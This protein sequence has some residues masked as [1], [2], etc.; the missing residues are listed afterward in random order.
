MISWPPNMEGADVIAFPAR[1]AVPAIAALMLAV[2]CLPAVAQD[3]PRLNTNQQYVEENSASTTLDTADPETGIES[4]RI[5]VSLATAI[6]AD[7]CAL[8]NL[9]YLDPATVNLEE[10]K[11]REAEGILF[12]PRAGEMLYRVKTRP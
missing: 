8:I 10:W 9:G 5:R 4:P 7:R 11:G 2:T 12:V 1:A 6:P 3:L